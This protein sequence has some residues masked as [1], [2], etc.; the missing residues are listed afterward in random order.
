[1][2]RH[3]VD[4]MVPGQPVDKPTRRSIDDWDIEKAFKLAESIRW[5]GT[6]P[7]AFQFVTRSRADDITEVEEKKSNMYFFGG[8]EETLK[9]I[10][11]KSAA[12]DGPLIKRMEE[13]GVERVFVPRG[14]RLVVPLI[15][16]DKVLDYSPPK[17]IVA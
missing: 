6:F 13:L 11:A 8:A 10:K 9:E 14:S 2:E 1:M 5:G 16:G 7:Y 4:F 3:F 17:Y 12:S 15:E